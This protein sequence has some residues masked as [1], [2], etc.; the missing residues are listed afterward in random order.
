MLGEIEAE[1]VGMQYHKAKIQPSEQV[2]LER[3]SK[4]AYDRRAIRVEN[5][6]FEPVGYLPRKMAS[7]LAPLIDSEK[8]RL[9]G[10]VPQSHVRNDDESKGRCPLVLTVFQTK[11]GRSLLEKG[12]PKSGLEALHQVIL[13]TYHNAERYRNPEMILAVAKGLQRLEKENLL[14]ETRLLLAL[15]PRLAHEARM[16]QGM[17]ATVQFRELL[18]TLTIGQPAHHHNLTFFP[19]LWPEH[20][21][22]CF[23]LLSTA[24]EAGEAVVEEINESG[25]VPNLAVTNKAQCPLLILRA[26][27]SSGPNR[28]GSSTS[29]SWWPRV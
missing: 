7:W 17:R 13:Q 23:R 15:L 12:E 28:T 11:K 29:P 9:D 25:S 10:Y 16:L 14:P 18:R 5:G 24:I 19:L 6:L 1:I 4:N 2:N 27:S 21:Q 20:H 8:I 26:R 22:A 3:H